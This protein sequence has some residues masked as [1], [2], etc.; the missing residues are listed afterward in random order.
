MCCFSLP[1]R[2]VSKTR[3]FARPLERGRQLLVYGMTVDIPEDLAMVLPIPVPPGS[4]EDAV[5]FVDLSSCPTF[6]DDVAELFPLA[7]AGPKGF[8]LA[9]ASRAM[10]QTL[11]VHDVGDFEASFAPRAEDF[12]RLDERFR[13]PRE[14]F[15]SLPEYADWGFC[16]FKLRKKRKGKGGLLGLFGGK[17]GKG[18]EGAQKVHPMAFDFPR[19]DA[20][21]LFFPTVHVHDGEVHR[22]AAF[23]HEL[24]CQVAREWE[25]LVDWQRSPAKADA[26]AARAKAWVEPSAHVFQ[27]RLQGEL[28]NRDTWMTEV[29]LRRR[30][31]IGSSFRLRMRAAWEHVTDD[32]TRPLDAN[33]KRWLRVT[34]EARAAIKESVARELEALLASDAASV[35]GL[36]PFRDDLPVVYPNAY[37]AFGGQLAVPDV[38]STGCTVSF[39]AHTE[40]IEPQELTVAFRDVP[41]AGARA[42]VQKAFQDALDRASR[43]V[44]LH[45]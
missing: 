41:N 14:V 8:G 43:D 19:R 13:I 23:D 10:V 21:A 24:Y 30:T 7:Y 5:R 25:P 2:M 37:E 38:A 11:E 29:A 20:S 18:E 34:E 33:V 44:A 28:P 16:V 17:G 9:P 1:V 12:D 42:L 4:A 6:L 39:F 27:Q 31:A 40:R 15:E 45:A 26:V 3:I 32:G 22:T 35:L 36:I